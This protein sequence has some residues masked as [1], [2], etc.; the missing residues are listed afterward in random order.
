[1]P[2]IAGTMVSNMMNASLP[3]GTSGAPTTFTA[4]SSSG[5]MKLR[6]T[7]TASTE[8]SAGTTLSGTGYSDYTMTTSSTASSAGSNVTL[9]AVSGGTSWTNGSGSNWTIYSCEVQDNANTRAW[10]GNFT[11]AP[12]TV[13][14]GNTF[15]VAQNAVTVSLS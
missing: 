4:L 6:L 12:I 11:G 10:Y 13:A 5:G 9:P 7:S 8:S 14:N 3:T 15:A 1:M 2:A